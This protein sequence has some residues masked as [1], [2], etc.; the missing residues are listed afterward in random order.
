MLCSLRVFKTLNG[1]ENRDRVFIPQ[2]EFGSVNP[3]SPGPKVR[4]VPAHINLLRLCRIT[5]AVDKV[6]LSDSATATEVTNNH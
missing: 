3:G 2:P 5:F 1:M 4:G 6:P